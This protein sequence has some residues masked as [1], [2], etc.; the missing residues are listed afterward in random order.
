M[1]EILHNLTCMKPYKWNI[2]HINCL[3]GFSPSTV[4]HIARDETRDH[5]LGTMKFFVYIVYMGPLPWW[6]DGSYI[7]W[8]L[9]GG[10]ISTHKPKLMTCECMFSFRFRENGFQKHSCLQLAEQAPVAC[11][12]SA[13]T[14][15]IR[16]YDICYG[17][18][19]VNFK[20]IRCGTHW[21][22]PGG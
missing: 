16:G 13:S 20:P 19:R 3:A 11:F 12:N 8:Q 18:S 9:R 4:V 7:S 22:S 5:G 14:S 6:T 17:L 21:G 15:D 2:Y 10:I 1:E